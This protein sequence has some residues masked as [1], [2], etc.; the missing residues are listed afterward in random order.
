M[1]LLAN[2][3]TVGSAT[4]ASRLLGFVRDV[5]L[6]AFVGAGPVADAFLV[7]FRLPN[8][9]RRLFAEGAFNAAFVP[10]FA[11]RLEEKG[12]DGARSFAEEILAALLWTLIAL[13]ALAQI[14]MPALVYLLAPGFA[15]SP[16]KFDLTVLLSRIAFPYLL[17][18]SLIAFLGGILNSFGKFAVAA[19][20]PVLLNVVMISALALIGLLGTGTDP[21]SGIILASGVAIA[22]FVQLG[23][24]IWGVRRERFPLSMR[25]PRFTSGVR[26]L[27]TLGIPGV[28]AGGI[29]QIN[30]MIGTIIASAQDSAV[31]YLYLA[32]RVYQLPLGIV[33][34][35][36][37][38]VLLPDLSRKLKSGERQAALDS[39]NRS[40]EF[41]MALTLPAAIALCLIPLEVVHVLFERGA[42]TREDSI[43]TAPALAAFAVGLPAFVLIKVFSPAFFAREDTKTPM[44]FAIV[45]V[46]VN[47]AGSLALFPVY[48]HVGIAIASSLA[49]WVNAALL[50]GA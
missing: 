25:R 26:R 3:A 48:Q 27:V 36:I 45:G 32:D 31:T 24:L 43:A 21:E 7:A 38:I 30:I 39:Q 37:G 41:A 49:G 14:A 18:M 22:G 10:L 6:A 17:C 46:V 12:R 47:V 29:T 16:E 1:A 28:V 13:T 2:F 40:L 15:D 33:G 20:A 34:I 11:G 19:L 35:A 42:F 9:F 50:G 4:M 23:A 44:W 5:L 8:L